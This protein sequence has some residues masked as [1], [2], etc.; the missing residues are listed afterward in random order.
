MPGFYI[1][2]RIYSQLK[3]IY[4][5]RIT[6][7]SAPDGYGKSGT[8]SKFVARSRPDG[9][10][11]RF[12]HDIESANEC[13]AA[14]CRLILGSELV[15]PLT[16]SE[17]KAVSRRFAAAEQ[18][19]NLLIV[20][21]CEGATEML[22]GNLYCTMLFTRYSCAHIVL[23]TDAL[24]FFN[25]KL[26]ESRNITVISENELALTVSETEEFL[27]R[28]SITDCDFTEM[29]RNT[30]GQIAK[31][32]FCAR[33]MKRGDAVIS[34]GLCELIKQAILDDLSPSRCFAALCTATFT[35]LDDKVIESL[36]NEPALCSYFGE[37]SI[38]KPMLLE[39]AQYISS[40]LPLVNVNRRSNH[41]SARRFFQLSA[42]MRFFELPQDVQRALQ[43][44]IA[45]EYM[46]R[47][48]TF[49][50]FCNFYLAGDIEEASSPE[51]FENISFA[52]V[53]R[54]RDFLLEFARTCP[55]D[56]KPLLPRLLR[57]VA[58]LMLTPHR[59]AIRYRFTEII[60]YVSTSP[61]YSG[62]ERRNLL[63]YAYALRTYEDFYY[64]ERMGN[65]I[66]RAYDL[67]SGTSI[68]IAPFYSWE[69]YT[70]SVFCLIHHYNTPIQTEAEQFA[71]YHSMYTEM[72]HHGEY[73]LSLYNA[74]V[75]YYICDIETSLMRALEVVKLCSRDLFLPT[76]I[77]AI[78]L[79]GKCALM[80]GNYEVFITCIESLTAIIKKY[81][82]TELGDMATIGLA[83]LC[84]FRNGGDVDMWRVSSRDDDEI[85]L[86]RY[87]APFYFYIRCF[88]MLS[89]GEYRMLLKRQHAYLRTADEV[90]SETIALSI[91]LAA[92]IAYM[93]LSEEV[94]A[95]GIFAEV[96]PV[97]RDSGALMPA[98]EL[99]MLYPA[100]FEQAAEK[101]PE[102]SKTLHQI[103]ATAAMYRR[104][105][106]AVRTRELTETDR[107]GSEKEQLFA[108]L[109][110]AMSVLEPKRKELGLT[111]TA[112]KYALY[113]S[114]R[115]SNEQIAEICG[116][117]VNSV[118]S[119]LKR[120]YAKLG[121]R[122]RG[123]LKYIF[124]IRE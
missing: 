48:M 14:I 56:N 70:P 63:C 105:I 121:I 44:C 59:D 115:Y 109:E 123:Q 83:Q 9:F 40:I 68:G 36:R 79:T 42:K 51:R 96:I 117:S 35:K 52:M 17:Y 8:V 50:A 88:A 47:K 94:A 53:M 61:D 99:C 97:L 78:N 37:D 43:R 72:I 107:H 21:D 55:L 119:S 33:I 104:N 116:T 58:L 16:A 75:C 102:L 30:G 34:Y 4:N 19:R 64:I 23:V 12:I 113:A 90:R 20:L 80:L 73:V 62:A 93:A 57:I 6:I 101:L 110:I 77:G 65:H 66:K 69:L 106:L 39:G 1:P 76:R 18:G 24:S 84:C 98:I 114:R 60:Q 32:S 13:F 91:R 11:C 31:L 82:S 26:A 87:A 45:K 22:L 41:W 3:C 124:K 86:N 27:H 38:S 95:T 81:S 5:E 67:Y 74:E 120:T 108:T 46:R 7:V 89:H 15:M 28:L 49:R 54:T 92:A 111:R 103:I 85:M 2:P 100:V 122:S 25:R 29:Q 118:K 10:S 112:L 71:R